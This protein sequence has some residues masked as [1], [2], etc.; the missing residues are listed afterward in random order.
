MSSHMYLLRV[1]LLSLI[2]MGG[3]SVAM[4]DDSAAGANQT[5]DS[6]GQELDQKQEGQFI[7]LPTDLLGVICAQFS[8]MPVLSRI[9]AWAILKTACKFLNNHIT[10][11]EQKQF[12]TND[13]DTLIKEVISSGNPALLRYLHRWNHISVSDEGYNDRMYAQ[14]SGVIQELRD[15]KRALEIVIIKHGD[16]EDQARYEHKAINKRLDGIKAMIKYNSIPDV[17]SDTQA[18]SLRHLMFMAR[19]DTGCCQL[20]RLLCGMGLCCLV[21]VAVGVTVLVT[22]LLTKHT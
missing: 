17:S 4:D 13:R 19:G 22:Q 12:Y 10:E 11:L 2:F 20:R 8:T 16:D 21:T 6:F 15:K 9:Q 14:F 7:Y 18:T 1:S 3:A 5:E